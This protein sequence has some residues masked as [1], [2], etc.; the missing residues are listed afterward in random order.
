[1]NFLKLPGQTQ[2]TAKPRAQVNLFILSAKSDC[3]SELGGPRSSTWYV[4]VQVASFSSSTHAASRFDGLDTK[5]ERDTEY[6]RDEWKDP[7]CHGGGTGE[8]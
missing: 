6:I 7:Q 4:P 1:M 8:A 2:A 5:N 3:V